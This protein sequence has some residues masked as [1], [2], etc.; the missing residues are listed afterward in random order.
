MAVKT[1][2]WASAGTARAARI[3][4]VTRRVKAFTGAPCASCCRD[5][6]GVAA[7]PDCH[8]ISGGR[9]KWCAQPIQNFGPIAAERDF[10][11]FQTE[12][13]VIHGVVVIPQQGGNPTLVQ[14]KLVAASL[15]V[16]GVLHQCA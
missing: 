12:L 11:G 2:V 16:Q 9:G 8:R 1:K 6:T 7:K 15:G 5:E 13:I 4:P 14:A 10:S 3:K